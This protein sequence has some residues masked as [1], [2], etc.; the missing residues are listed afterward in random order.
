MKDLTDIVCI[1]DRS[2]SMHLIKS[3]AE[4]GFNSFILE[5]KALPGNINIS[6]YLFDD[7]YKTLYENLPIQEVPA[8]VLIP[9]GTTALYDAIGK[10]ISVRGAYYAS[11]PEEEKP[12]K[13][14]VIIITDGLENASKEFTLKQINKMITHQ[15]E[16]YKWEF[17]FLAANQDAIQTAS[18]MGIPR[19]A[20]LTYDASNI[21]TFSA[22]SSLSKGISAQRM[23][24]DSSF[25]FDD[26]DREIQEELLKN[27]N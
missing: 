6:H 19:E 27:K 9:R 21:G 5:Q 1:T 12:N 25:S 17:I 23:C 14:I 15:K 20:S 18:S 3:D 11:L 7:R 24:P 10:T 2:G 26:K 4:G 22:Y 16:V 8:F 13:I